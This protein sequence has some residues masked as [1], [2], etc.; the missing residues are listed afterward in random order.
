VKGERKGEGRWGGGGRRERGREILSLFSILRYAG[1]AFASLKS[2]EVVIPEDE[3]PHQQPAAPPPPQ[4]QQQEDAPEGSQ[5]QD[6]SSALLVPLSE[7][8]D[9]LE[10]RV[11]EM[12]G[13]LGR[14]APP[15]ALRC[16]G[17]T[18]DMPHRRRVGAGGGLISRARA[19]G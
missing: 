3:D 12:A 13:L 16:A 15:P 9:A 10:I 14:G 11:T 2:D 19:N 17:L 5:Q 6:G 4:Q 18:R 8:S 1:D 7:E